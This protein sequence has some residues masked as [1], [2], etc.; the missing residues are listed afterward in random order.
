MKLAGR[1]P[2]MLVTVT[3]SD[4]IVRESQDRGLSVVEFVESLIDKGLATALNRPAL[5]SAIERIRALS[6]P[7]PGGKGLG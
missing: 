1:T 4:E 6:T 2:P 3:I 7:G 5:H